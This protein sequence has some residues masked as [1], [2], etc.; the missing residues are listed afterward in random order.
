MLAKLDKDKNELQD[1]LKIIT[2][3]L[4]L[5]HAHA[6]LAITNRSNVQISK[7]V[8]LYIYELILRS[9]SLLFSGIYTLKTV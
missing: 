6:L 8:Y 9:L 5:V 7:N 2:Y 4:V 3:P 1:S